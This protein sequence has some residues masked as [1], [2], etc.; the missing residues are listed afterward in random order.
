MPREP[1][2]EELAYYKHWELDGSY[3]LEP[4]TIT[5]G[6]FRIKW[7]FGAD[8]ASR[9]S[10]DNHIKRGLGDLF[11]EDTGLIRIEL[12]N[13]SYVSKPKDSIYYPSYW[14][15]LSLSSWDYDRFNPRLFEPYNITG[16]IYEGEA[17][18]MGSGKF[19]IT[20]EGLPI[21]GGYVHF[22]GT[23]N[24]EIIIEE[25]IKAKGWFGL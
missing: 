6:K 19:T 12:T 10:M 21:L 25:K 24:W 4:F 11:Y 8:E 2:W 16:N 18:F 13:L 9:S 5:G 23:G 22:G 7:V 17:Y 20:I 15:D 3:K 1:K 14:I